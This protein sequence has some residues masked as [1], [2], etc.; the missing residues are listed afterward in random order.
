LVRFFQNELPADRS[1][2]NKALALN[3]KSLFVLDGIGYLLTLLGDWDQGIKLIRHTMHTNRYY[4][5]YVHYA[6]WLDW[7]RQENYARAYLEAL[8]FKRHAVF[9][10]PLMKAVTL[11]Q[12]GRIDEGKVEAAKLVALKPDSKP[13]GAS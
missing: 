12:L 13:A 8:S 11:G 4:G 10:E 6:L 7:M 2:L 1:E 5:V 9:W 3:P